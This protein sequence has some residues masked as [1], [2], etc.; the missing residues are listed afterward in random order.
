[1]TNEEVFK[2]LSSTI[3]EETG[4]AIELIT[5]EKS[6]DD[7]DLDSLF[8]VTVLHRLEEE[9]GANLIDN[10]GGEKTIKE[11]VEAISAQVNG[12]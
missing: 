2:A 8:V 9:L 1:M 4:I 11:L 12:E 7:L 5:M 6:L 10:L 3:A